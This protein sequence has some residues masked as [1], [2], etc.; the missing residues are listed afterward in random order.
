M[1]ALENKVDANA[2]SISRIMSIPQIQAQMKMKPPPPPSPQLRRQA[3]AGEKG[4]A[5]AH[6]VRGRHQSRSLTRGDRRSSSSSERPSEDHHMVIDPHKGEKRPRSPPPSGPGTADES[7][8][9][10][11]TEPRPK[12][13]FK[14]ISFNLDDGLPP[15]GSKEAAISK[16]RQAPG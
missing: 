3:P 5:A 15:D 2:Q 16:L 11:K 6:S 14:P 9:V 13:Q 10:N 4:R 12:H 8:D 1:K 7:S